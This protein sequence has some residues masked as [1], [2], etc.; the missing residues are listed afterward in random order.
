MKKLSVVLLG[1]FFASSAMATVSLSNKDSK[2][3]QLLLNSSET[4]FAGTESSINSSTTS[5][6]DAGW[7]CLNKQK[8]A[9]KLEEGKS[10]IIK[11]GKIVEE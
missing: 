1:V 10:Y 2:Q 4:C 3:Y 6:V 7:A 5:K 9:V 8:P 11:D